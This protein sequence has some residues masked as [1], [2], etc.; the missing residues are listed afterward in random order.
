MVSLALLSVALSTFGES[1]SYHLYFP[2]LATAVGLRR[3]K[4]VTNFSCFSSPPPLRPTAAVLVDQFAE[5]N[6][7][8]R[9]EGAKG[10]IGSGWEVP[11]REEEEEAG[12]TPAKLTEF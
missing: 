9:R 12:S 11:G 7:G 1:T 6:F 10:R 4:R 3:R 5:S 2:S 8:A